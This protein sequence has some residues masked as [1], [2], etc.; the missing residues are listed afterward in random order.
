MQA[1]VFGEDRL[2]FGAYHPAAGQS[3]RHAVLF[4]GPLLNESMR[5]HAALRLMAESIAAKGYDVLR[6]D[7]SGM[8]N[9]EGDLAQIGLDDWQ[10]DTEFAAKELLRLS[11]ASQLSS[12]AT[13]FGA[14]FATCLSQ[15]MPISH[16]VFWDPV[17]SG[18]QWHERLEIARDIADR[19]LP[20]AAKRQASEYLG[21]LMSKD[22][23]LEL[24]SVRT[25][26]LNLAS[27]FVGFTNGACE[28]D[29]QEIPPADITRFDFECGWEQMTFPVLYPH[30]L[31]KSVG[32]Q[33]A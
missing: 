20:S 9:S 25:P 10:Q 19:E 5:P 12:V 30:E 28:I 11:G 26:P 13:R 15:A 21:H 22:F 14:H 33:F 3:K 17:F 29:G 27:C 16:G 32:A 24:D 1:V 2:L 4:V 31:S 7:Y 6:F 23:A 18:R 8:G